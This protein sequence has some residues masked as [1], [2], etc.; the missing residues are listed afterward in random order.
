MARDDDDTA[1]SAEDF[2]GAEATCLSMNLR[3]RAADG[4]LREQTE[5]AKLR[6][7]NLLEQ[8]AFELSHLRFRRFS[9]YARFALEVAGFLVVLLVVCGLGSM[10]W[11]ASR[12]RGL[13]VDAFSVPP[14]LAQ[15]G[16]TGSV[17]ANRLI[18][19]LGQLQAASFA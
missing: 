18:D 5:L 11:N 3:S 9:D 1:N 8:N 17:V 10:V 7:I 4:Y 19:K 2:G 14:D 13:V 15:T 12:D 16:M 6:K